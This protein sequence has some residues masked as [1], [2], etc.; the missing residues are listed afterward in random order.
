MLETLSTIVVVILATLDV[1]TVPLVEV[2]SVIDTEVT[3]GI[4]LTDVVMEPRSPPP[5][6]LP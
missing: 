4:E 2:G 1:A 5:I 6:V 3:G